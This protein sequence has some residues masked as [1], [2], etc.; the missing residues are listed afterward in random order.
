MIDIDEWAQ[1]WGIPP[2]AIQELAPTIERSNS[3][4]TSEAGVQ[5][6]ARLRLSQEGCLVFRNNVGVH[7]VNE[8]TCDRCGFRHAADR[9]IRYGLANDSHALNKRVK[10]SDLI[11]A[12]PVLIKPE[13]VGK[14]IGRFIAYETKNPGWKYTGT[15]HEIAQK[16]FLTIMKALGCETGFIQ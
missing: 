4:A 2:Q 11:G 10:S 5:Q 7:A 13:H 3:N 12:R 6:R 15:E 14:T 8:Y 16:K 9:Y 1:R